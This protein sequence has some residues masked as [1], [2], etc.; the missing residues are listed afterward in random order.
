MPSIKDLWPDRWLKAEHLQGKRPTVTI[1]TVTIEKLFNPRSRKEEPRLI[2]SFF[3]K[4]LRLPVNKTQAEA[5]ATITR[6]DDY[7]LW[8]GCQAVLSAGRAP[9][10]AA[11]IVISPTADKATPPAASPAPASEDDGQDGEPTD[12]PTIGD[13]Q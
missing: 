11:T 5:L 9:N 12:P 13:W 2:L 4:E 10:G 3:K 6:T 7:L 8:H 1:Q